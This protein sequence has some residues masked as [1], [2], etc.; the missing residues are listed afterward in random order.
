MER[1]RKAGQ[2]PPR[3]V[4][5]TEEEEE[6]DFGIYAKCSGVC[7][8]HFTPHSHILAELKKRM[9]PNQ[10]RKVSCGT[11]DI[12]FRRHALYDLK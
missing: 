11:V 4:A 2:N 12:T 7:A 1:N 9:V 5:P 10:G 6:E 3:V 8:F